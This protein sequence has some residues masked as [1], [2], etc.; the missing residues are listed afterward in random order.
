MKRVLVVD[1]D[2]AVLHYFLLLLTQSQRCEVTV[3]SDSVKA[4]EAIE[5]RTFQA[6]LLDMDMPGVHG[7]EILR[8][9]RNRQP[10]TPVIVITGVEDAEL[11]AES[12]RLGAF[13]YLYK[14]VGEAELLCTLDCAL[15]ENAPLPDSLPSPVQNY[16]LSC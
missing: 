10:A 16:T 8:S 15:Q 9:M 7:R 2:A 6:V 4:L 14:P 11:A 1:D 5:S 13:A 3:L 12:M